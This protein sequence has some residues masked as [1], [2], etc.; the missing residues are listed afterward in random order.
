M[1]VAHQAAGRV[2]QPL[3]RA[4]VRLDRARGDAPARRPTASD[5]PWRASRVAVA[6]LDRG[7]ALS[8]D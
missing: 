8:P 3:A 6:P 7:L 2:E 4:E 1:T 5:L